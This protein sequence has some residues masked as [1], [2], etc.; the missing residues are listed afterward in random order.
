MNFRIEYD[1]SVETEVREILDWYKEKSASL[2][3]NFLY[4]LKIA[5]KN[6]LLN[7]FAFRVVSIHGIRRIVLKKFPYKVYFRENNDIIFI[8]AIIH[9]SRSNRYIRKRLKK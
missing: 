8:L 5:E 1:K 2:A 7:P 4:Q 3:L 6:L 9:Q